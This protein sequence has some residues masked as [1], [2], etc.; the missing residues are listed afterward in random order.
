M[1]G[2]L[3]EVTSLSCVDRTFELCFALVEC[4]WTLKGGSLSLR[5]RL[6]QTSESTLRQLCD[7]TSDSVLIEINGDI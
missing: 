4:E 5:T 6:H 7:D 1:N 3:T 2:P